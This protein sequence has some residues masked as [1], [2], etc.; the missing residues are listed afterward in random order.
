M[1]IE[2]TLLFSS[3]LAIAV[4][5]I[6]G[7]IGWRLSRRVVQSV[8][9]R[10]AWNSFSVWWY[11]LATTTLIGGFQNLLGAFGLMDLALFLTATYINLLVLCIMLWGLLYYL[12]YLF[13]GNSRSVIPLIVFYAAY[14]IMLMYYTTS[15]VPSHIQVDR[16]NITLAYDNQQDGPFFVLVLVLLLAPQI[17]GALAYFSIYFRL[18]D[19][20]QKYR[21]LL[22][23]WSIIIWFLS[24]VIALAGGLNDQDWW[25]LA[26]RLIGLAAAATILMA[27][28]PPGWLKVRYGVRSLGDE[29]R[30]QAANNF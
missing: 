11:G 28:L 4:A 19:I 24:P 6:Y 20:T 9:A 2:P 5:A 23:S 17:L 18:T 21:V 26:S 16:W 30:D 3:M 22:V 25:Q 10:L 13:T 27:Y 7:Y 1:N 14:Y 8:E 12:I 15:S 29:M